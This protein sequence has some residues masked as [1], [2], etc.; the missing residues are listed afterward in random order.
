MQSMKDEPKTILDGLPEDC[1]LK[2]V[3]YHLYV[4][5][6]I[7]KGMERADREATKIQEEIE[8]KFNRWTESLLESIDSRF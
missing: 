8:Q 5:E 1:A 4:A 6:K 7:H 2:D 3:Q